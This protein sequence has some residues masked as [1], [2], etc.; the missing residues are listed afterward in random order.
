MPGKASKGKKG[1][2]ALYLRVTSIWDLGRALAGERSYALAVKSGSGYRLICDAEQVG[3]TK[4]MLYFDVK[5]SGRYLVYTADDESGERVEIA[6][7]VAQRSD[8]YKSQKTPIVEVKKSPY[9]EVE[10]GVVRKMSI[11][12]VRDQ[13]ALIRALV[14]GMGEDEQLKVYS[15]MHGSERMI[16]S[17]ELLNDHDKVFTYARAD[18]AEEFNTISYDYNND[19]IE[20]SKSPN[21]TSKIHI[22]V[23]NLAEEPPFFKE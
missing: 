1:S 21:G 7:D 11:L 17:F 3:E 5:S 20:T 6:D 12:E 8:R 2:K 15:F 22:R 4:I 19:V 13:G 9:S 16:G 18:S 14:N 23:V 10:N